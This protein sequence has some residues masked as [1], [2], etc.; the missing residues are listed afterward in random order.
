MTIA[1]A[2][3]APTTLGPAGSSEICTP[4]EPEWPALRRQARPQTSDCHLQAALTLHGGVTTVGTIVCFVDRHLCPAHGVMALGPVTLLAT[5]L[6]MHAV[7]RHTRTSVLTAECLGDR[8]DLLVEIPGVRV[9]S[10][11]PRARNPLGLAPIGRIAADWGIEPRG[12]GVRIWASVDA[13]PGRHL[14]A[15]R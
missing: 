12:R 13:R 14:A 3:T 2:H 15:V 6:G 9:A 1:A 7:R 8:I 10:F 5:E 4:P 11:G